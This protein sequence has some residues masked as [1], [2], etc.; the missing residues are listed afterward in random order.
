MQGHTVR[1]SVHGQV[2][3]GEQVWEETRLAW[4]GN[5]LEGRRAVT[6]T[7][8]RIDVVEGAALQGRSPFDSAQGDRERSSE[9]KSRAMMNSPTGSIQ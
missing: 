7:S 6:L 1:A 3:Q 2:W 4:M 5:S 8:F 9:R